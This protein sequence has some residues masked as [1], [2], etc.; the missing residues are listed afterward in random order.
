MSFTWKAVNSMKTIAKWLTDMTSEELDNKLV[1][2]GCQVC[3]EFCV[4]HGEWCTVGNDICSAHSDR[5]S[6]EE[7]ARKSLELS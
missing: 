4:E 5:T 6:N 2:K 1:E 7:K 3:H